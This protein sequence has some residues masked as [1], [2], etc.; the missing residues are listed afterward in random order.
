MLDF[1]PW[2]ALGGGLLIGLAG[3]VLFGLSGRI[4]GV[5]GVAG[6]LWFSARADRLWRILFLIGLI[7][8]TGLWALLGGAVPVPRPHFPPA[9]LVI[10][11]LLV[12]YGTSLGGG[13]TSG[14]GVC[15]LA[16]FSL[17]SILATGIFLA[18][19]IA[20]TFFVRHVLHIA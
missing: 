20:T 8:G 18:V 15:G 17:R 12:G 3:V 6:G 14:H 13:C 7:A 16:R 19:A 2:S 1:T 11:G 5:S 10:S 4:A 9:L